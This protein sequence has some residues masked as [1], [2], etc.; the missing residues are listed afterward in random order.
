MIIL[1]EAGWSDMSPVVYIYMLSQLEDFELKHR[2]AAT[3]SFLL[4]CAL[5]RK[6]RR[7]APPLALCG[8]HGHTYQRQ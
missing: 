2:L 1:D 5:C 8:S 4:P 6:H 3:V 7:T